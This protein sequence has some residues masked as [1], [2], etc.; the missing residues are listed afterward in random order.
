MSTALAVTQY[1]FHC[2]IVVSALRAVYGRL[3]PPHQGMSM[4]TVLVPQLYVVLIH[5]PVKS[6][7][8][9][10]H[11]GARSTHS[12]F[13]VRLDCLPAYRLCIAASV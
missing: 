13:Q 4:V 10:S 9:A 3:Q 1:T 8:S 2:V 7:I 6:I 11:A 5:A 12:S